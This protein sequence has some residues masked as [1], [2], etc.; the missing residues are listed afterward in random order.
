M[1]LGYADRLSAYPNKGVCGLPELR[2][3]RRSLEFKLA[4]LADMFAGARRVVFLTGAG[5]S[6]SSGIPDFRG[7]RGIW[8]LAQAEEARVAR[9]KDDVGPP[10]KK[11]RGSSGNPRGVIETSSGNFQGRVNYKPPGVSKGQLRGIGT[12]DTPEEAGQAVTAAEAKLKAEGPDAVWPEQART[13]LHKRG[14]VRPMPNP[15]STS[16]FKLATTRILQA[17]PPKRA[18]ARRWGVYSTEKSAKANL[19]AEDFE[20]WKTEHGTPAGAETDPTFGLMPSTIY[21]PSKRSATSTWQRSWL[22]VARARS[23]RRLRWSRLCRVAGQSCLPVLL[24]ALSDGV[25][26]VA[27]GLDLPICTAR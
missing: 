22:R 11:K 21:Q 20:A 26:V 9:A 16:S 17:P 13:N 8:T 15:T 7:P 18:T 10:A 3:T 27:W 4:T 1:S 5:I 12:F 6:T 2:E 19:S 23:L 24:R 14:E 25:P